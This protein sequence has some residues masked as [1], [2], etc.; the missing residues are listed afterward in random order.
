MPS[1][2][3]FCENRSNG[4]DKVLKGVNDGVRYQ[5]N[6]LLNSCDLRENRPKK[7]LIKCVSF[8]PIRLRK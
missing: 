3:A 1:K 7:D 2:S 8:N 4:S 6:L 5:H